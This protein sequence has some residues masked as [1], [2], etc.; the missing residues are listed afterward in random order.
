MYM[1]DKARGGEIFR[2]ILFGI[3]RHRYEGNTNGS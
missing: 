1:E 2:K 3:A